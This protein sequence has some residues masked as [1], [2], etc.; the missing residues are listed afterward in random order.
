[1]IIFWPVYKL[2][3]L[4]SIPLIGDFD[5]Q[6]LVQITSIKIACTTICWPVLGWSIAV[7]YVPPVVLGVFCIQTMRLA[8]M[9]WDIFT[10]VANEPPCV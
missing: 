8:T 10:F 1:M 2:G 4:L 5:I 6:L 3:T 9:S 7:H